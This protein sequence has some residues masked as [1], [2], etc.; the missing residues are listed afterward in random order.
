MNA[1]RRK[2]LATVVEMLEEVISEEQEAFDN[3][4]YSLQDGERG[5]TMEDGISVLEDA[6]TEIEDFDI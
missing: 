2:K 6:K 4:P 5:Q 3:M 1:A